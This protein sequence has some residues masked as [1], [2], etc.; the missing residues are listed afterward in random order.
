MNKGDVLNGRYE[1]SELCGQGGMAAVWKARDLLD[2]RTVAVKFLRPETFLSYFAEAERPQELPR[3]R[4]RFRREGALLKS[5]P[6]P[7]IVELYDQ[8]DHGPDPYI[9]MRYIDGVSL[10]DFVNRHNLT[11]VVSAAVITQVAEA[12]AYVDSIPVVHRDIKPDNIIIDTDGRAVLIDFGIALPLNPGTTRYTQHGVTLG[13]R[14]YQAP[15]QLDGDAVITP[16][17]DV[18]ALGCVYYLLLTGRPPF[19]LE[20]A[21][22]MKAHLSELPLAPSIAAN[23]VIP[24]AVDD[25][26]LRMLAKTADERPSAAE[27]VIALRAF[28]PQPGEPTPSPRFDPDP[29]NIFRNPQALPIKPA[30]A[31][32]IP[33]GSARARR[34]Q[35][36]LSR[37]ALEEDLQKARQEL[38]QDEPGAAVQALTDALPQARTQLGLQDQLVSAICLTV[39]DHLRG[40]GHCGQASR[41]YGDIVDAHM[42]D[43]RFPDPIHIEAL[44]GLGECRI[45]FDEV[46]PALTAIKT[47]LDALPHLPEPVAA[48]LAARC[49]D[50]ATELEELRRDE[51]RALRDRL[52]EWFKHR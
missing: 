12:L 15:E 27:V 52:D 5:L 46:A 17:V 39:A 51:V 18:Y 21:G 25:L 47:L 16:K 1:L 4:S 43:P 38:D 48:H 41:L 19:P 11:P 7:G 3:L 33:A 36:W 31:Q 14:G 32:G 26:V 42:E 44:V 23:R 24:D 20:G 6:H 9:V 37:R 30:A 22:L 13:S 28:L 50:I 49:A 8:G 2:N 34:G 29:T 35:K 40:L 45:R 10:E